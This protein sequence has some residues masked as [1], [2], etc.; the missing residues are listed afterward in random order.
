MAIISK[1]IDLDVHLANLRA[2]LP[3]RM[4]LHLRV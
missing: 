3:L 1:E 2:K 4:L